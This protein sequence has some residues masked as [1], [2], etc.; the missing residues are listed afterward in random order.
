MLEFELG[1][2]SAFQR[3]ADLHRYLMQQSAVSVDR[4]SLR[5][6]FEPSN[7]AD[8]LASPVKASLDGGI[9]A[10]LRS[11]YDFDDFVDVVAHGSL[12]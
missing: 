2:R 3:E 8:R 5:N 1:S 12:P 11:S 6:N 4:A 10:I 9:L 7:I